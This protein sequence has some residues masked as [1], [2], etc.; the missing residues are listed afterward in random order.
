[1]KSKLER[2]WPVDEEGK[3]IYQNDPGWKELG[4]TDEQRLAA[5]DRDKEIREDTAR[6]WREQKGIEVFVGR[7]R[8]S[9]YSIHSVGL[10]FTPEQWVGLLD[11]EGEYLPAC[12][13]NISR[14]R[15]ILFSVMRESGLIEVEELGEA[16]QLIVG[17][18]CVDGQDDDDDPLKTI[19]NLWHEVEDYVEL[20]PYIRGLDPN[21][22]MDAAK[23]VYN[24]CQYLNFE[25]FC[26][27]KTGD[28]EKDKYCVQ[29]YR[30]QTLLKMLPALK[31]LHERVTEIVDGSLEGFAVCQDG[32]VID[33]RVSGW[34]IFGEEDEAKKTSD[35]LNKHSKKDNP[36]TVRPVICSLEKGLE[37]KDQ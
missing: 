13:G 12:C 18:D 11:K 10:S 5:L 14:V 4:W 23:I 29:K 27:G 32:E 21:D 31:T 7:Y 20:D 36:T 22:P 9:P 6:I 26:A 34:L 2:I 30:M 1:M 35:D 33:G 3:I 8:Q 28:E 17:H 19:V 25:M 37:F 16:A 24:S 15:D